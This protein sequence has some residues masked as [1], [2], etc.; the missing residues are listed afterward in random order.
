MKQF[1]LFVSLAG[2]ALYALLV[3]THDAIT[4]AKSERIPV[5]HISTRSSS[6]SAP[7]FVGK[8]PSEQRAKFADNRS[9]ASTAEY[10]CDIGGEVSR[11]HPQPRLSG[12]R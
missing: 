4:D 2:A 6:P 5:P 9:H 1:L 3:F 11:L 7:E 10:C 12:P 8:L